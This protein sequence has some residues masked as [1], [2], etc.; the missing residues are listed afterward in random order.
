MTKSRQE[1]AGGRGLRKCEALMLSW[2]QVKMITPGPSL[3][4]L[5]PTW[6]S[7]TCANSPLK[8][9]VLASGVMTLSF[10]KTRA[11]SS[12]SIW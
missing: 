10:L 12:L 7:V 9:T 8:I 1:D 11:G 3:G 5:C 4:P 6:K 2:L